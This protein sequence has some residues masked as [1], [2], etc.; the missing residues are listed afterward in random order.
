MG[1]VHSCATNTVLHF[2]S[3]NHWLLCEITFFRAD[4]ERFL[5][6]TGWVKIS[7]GSSEIIYFRFLEETRD[8]LN[9]AVCMY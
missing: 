7:E 3:I 2:S 6:K 1:N 8:S 5:A 9:A 4:L